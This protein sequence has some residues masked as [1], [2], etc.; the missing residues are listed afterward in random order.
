[1]LELESVEEKEEN[2][3][4]NDPNMK[5]EK[6]SCLKK[7]KLYI[8]IGT[9]I[10][11]I[12]ALVVTLCLLLTKNSDLPEDIKNNINLEVYSDNDDEEISF[13]SNEYNI[14]QKVN[15]KLYVDEKKYSFVKSM[16]LNKGSHKIIIVFEDTIK[17]CQNMFTNCKNIKSINFNVMNE[18]DNMDYIFSGCSSLLSINTE[19]LITSNVTSMKNMFS[20]CGSLSQI[21]LENFDTAKV[22]NMEEMFSGCKSIENF[23]L[24]SFN[25]TS[26]VNMKGMF[27]ECVNLKNL[28]LNNFDTSFVTNM[29][30]MFNEC[31]SIKEIIIT[32]K[33]EISLFD[34]FHVENMYHIF[35][36]CDSLESIDVSNF[37]LY[38]IKNNISDLFGD[39]EKNLYLK[40]VYN[41]LTKIKN[42]ENIIKDIDINI[43]MEITISSYKE[44]AYIFGDDFAI[45]QISE[46]KLYVDNQEIN[47][48]NIL[49]L[50]NNKQHYIKILLEGKLED[51]SNMFEKC[52]NMDIRFSKNFEDNKKRIFDKSKIRNMKSMFSQT[53]YLFY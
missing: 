35:Y 38:K 45:E 7:Y 22:T 53:S 30:K 39:L 34:T 50:E 36:G 15:L 16:K 24:T 1:M 41:N 49:H 18:C 51:A 28:D 13:L 25:T 20:N 23:N 4:L 52:Q 17:S 21:N 27:S 40:Q 9:A 46:S 33:N 48:T 31:N 11:I 43:I 8:I 19:K 44:Y 10:I 12:I 47:L 32:K 37:I 42:E 6:L 3:P 26:V 29:E 2:I 14:D 5:M